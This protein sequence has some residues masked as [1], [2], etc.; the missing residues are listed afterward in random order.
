MLVW[1][2]DKNRIQQVE[3]PT[4][5]TFD[6]SVGTLGLSFLWAVD[7]VEGIEI[8]GCNKV[9]DVVDI[10]L[11][12]KKSD[13]SILLTSSCLAVDTKVLSWNRCTV[14]N[15]YV[16]SGLYLFTIFHFFFIFAHGNSI[17]NVKYFLHSDG[18][19]GYCYLTAMHI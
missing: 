4:V 1:K 10:I 8:V 13:S 18:N 6:F 5:N 14:Y 3:D 11:E 16:P 12:C 17:S 19:V 2:R 9:V 15:V 7:V